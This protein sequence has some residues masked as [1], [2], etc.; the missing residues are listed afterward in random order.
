[1]KI[2][3]NIIV[4]L[5]M[6]SRI[7]M[8]IFEWKED[9][10][11][12]ALSF[13]GLVGVIIGAIEYVVFVIEEYLAVP[14]IVQTLMFAVIPL[15]VTGGFHVDGFMD[16]A[17][18]LS[19]YK[20][21]E[22]KLR[23]LKDPHIGAFAVIAFAIYGCLFIAFTYLLF[24]TGNRDL[25]AIA[26]VGFVLLRALGGLIS[27]I[28]KLSKSDGMLHEETKQTD[29]GPKIILIATVIISIFFMACFNIPAAILI[30]FV[31]S[32]FVI[33]YRRKCYKEF[34]GISGDTIGYFITKGEL[35]VVIIAAILSQII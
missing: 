4:A 5:S 30:M 26:C 2:I 11:K 10:T 1:M 29:K 19:S 28:F 8:P 27:V 25:I 6:Y 35:F 22:E 7:P 17:D 3:R 9:D 31:L 23:I 20:S 24:N 18:A 32:L 33:L 13:I 34:G 14:I 12:Y 16:V 15:I 21:K